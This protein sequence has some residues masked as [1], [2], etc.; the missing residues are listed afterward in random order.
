MTEQMIRIKQIT[1]D[2]NAVI[3][4]QATD[5]N[6]NHDPY[7]HGLLNGMIMAK[8]IISNED[9]EFYEAP[10]KWLSDPKITT[11]Q[12][13]DAL[14]QALT[15]DPSFA[16]SWHCNLAMS[17]YHAMP[18]TQTQRVEQAHK[19]RHTI[20]NEGATRFMQLCFEIKTSKEFQGK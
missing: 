13:F 2:L 11:K 20:A 19:D 14:K 18:E 3:A 16:H 15:D 1:D 6:W 7:M 4:T 10:G 5:G 9:A 17:F 12:A 8:S